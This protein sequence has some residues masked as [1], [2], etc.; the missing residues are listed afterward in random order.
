[1]TAK[2]KWEFDSNRIRKIEAAGYNVT[3]VWESDIK[4]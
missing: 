2:E 1:M 3:I 4:L